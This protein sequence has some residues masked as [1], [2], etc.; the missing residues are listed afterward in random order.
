M[1]VASI[2]KF[3]EDLPRWARILLAVFPGS[4]IGGLYRIF[5]FIEGKENMTLVGAILALC[6]FITGE[7]FWIVDIVTVIL[8]DKI[9]VLAD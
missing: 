8:H 1:T 3:Y 2:I 7:I 6:P 5:K 9:S 4:L